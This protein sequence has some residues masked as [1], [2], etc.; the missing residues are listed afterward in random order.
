MLKVG[1]GGALGLVLIGFLVTA[2]V[3]SD[4]SLEEMTCD[5]AVS[6]F[7]DYRDGQLGTRTHA[8]LE[9]HLGHC[10]RCRDR[11]R[12]QYLNDA[13]RLDPVPEA[14]AACF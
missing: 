8:Q 9:A 10:P 2:S 5:R 11:F 4:R 6:L 12:R 13:H 3:L 14:L 7:A 1:S